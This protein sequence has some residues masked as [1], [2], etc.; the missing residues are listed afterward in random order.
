VTDDTQG[1][2]LRGLRVLDAGSFIAAPLAA[3]LLGDW[4]AEVVKLEPAGGDPAREIGEQAAPGMSSTF[5]SCNRGKRSVSLDLRAAES[6]ATVRRL[7]ATCDI[8]VHNLP[9]ATARRLGLDHD[10]LLERRADAVLCTV[11]AFGED[12]PY[13]GR[14]ALD[15]IVQA[16]AGLAAATGEP[17]GE[18]MRCAAPVVDTAAGF[19]AAA[20]SLAALHARGSRG[21]HV[22]VAL[23][24]VALAFQGPL[25]ALRSLL[26]SPPPR[27]GNGSYAVL[28]DQVA[29]ADGLL[30][31][32]VW[33]DRRWA[34]LCDVLGLAALTTDPRFVTNADRC[35]HQDALRPYLQEA[36]ARHPG[37]ALEARLL[38]AGIS[39]AVTQDLD[40]VVADQHVV[41][42]GAVYGETRLGTAPLTLASGPVRIDGRRPRAALR[43]PYLGE[44][45]G[46]VLAELLAPR[47]EG[48]RP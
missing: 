17:A 42:S 19:A 4:G 5:V 31:F 30:A 47:L 40:A 28:G 10:A 20:V 29:T 22:S 8:V 7:A 41:A 21:R 45:T 13:A 38:A 25:L 16:M 43:P 44:H 27:R 36:F 11:T 23:L 35:A 37:R 15:P 48:A 24:D 34:A 18:P 12:G 33:D 32:V 1:Q 2:L 9:P 39:C 14:A 3:M 46:A 6:A 26:G